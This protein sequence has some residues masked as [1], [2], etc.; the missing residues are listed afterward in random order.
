MTYAADTEFSA[1]EQAQEK[2]R[3]EAIQNSL[4]VEDKEKIVSR[5]AALAERQAQVQD[6][7]I[8]PKVGIEDIPASSPI[9]VN[10]L[11]AQSSEQLY[12]YDAAT[13]G[14]VYQRLSYELPA[15]TQA[16]LELLP[17][18]CQCL[19]KLGVGERDYLETQRWQADVASNVVAFASV[20]GGAESVDKL[21]A[22]LIV[23]ART[24][25]D[26]FSL[27]SEY[28]NE[29]MSK[30]RFDELKRIAELHTETNSRMQSGA[31]AGS[32]EYI[33]GAA[34]SGLT[35]SAQLIYKLHGLSALKAYAKRQESLKDESQVQVLADNLGLL[36]AKICA[37]K[38]KI[39]LVD[40]EDKLAAYEDVL[41][42]DARN[43]QVS[44][45][46]KSWAMEVELQSKQAW[47]SNT[48]VN[49]IARAFPSVSMAHEDSAA[50]TVLAEFL[51][52]GFLHQA[53]REKGGAY[54][55]K[56]RQDC[57]NG[58]FTLYSYRDPRLVETLTDFEHAL[59]WLQSN[60]HTERALEEAV[61]A[62]I[63]IVDKPK[64]A[65]YQA[66]DDFLRLAAQHC[67]Q[68]F[69]RYRQQIL[70]VSIADLKRVAQNLLAG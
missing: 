63:S 61:L 3:L 37:V 39:V 50:L 70:Q 28:L 15:L 32:Q 40:T 26:N 31:V 65:Q 38:P 58:T 66:L 68:D 24:L 64:A 54:G 17:F 20:K 55:G 8:M 34:V 12:C 13:N 69:E 45:E 51:H 7:D 10:L 49:F 35:N 19:T 25:S 33:I 48:Q 30:L 56:A 36:H 52:Q 60:E 18:Y 16:E 14:L 47:Y 41:A 11:E 44:A 6:I 46:Q 29:T 22:N 21:N 57:N 27:M 1:R 59:E 4:S 53:I 23:S 67:E 42:D 43:E 5:A 2:A 9:K 62:S